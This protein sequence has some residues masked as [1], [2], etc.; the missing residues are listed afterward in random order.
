MKLVGHRGAKG[1]APENTIRSIQ[2]A[3]EY[4]VDEVEIDVR[5]TSDNVP[6]LYHNRSVSTNDGQRFKISNCKYEDLKKYKHDITTLDEAISTVH[7]KSKLCIEVKPRVNIAPIVKLIHSR[8]ETDCNNSDLQLAS[9]SFKILK[10]FK[11]K[12][13]QVELVVIESW[14]GVRAGY[15]ARYL[16]AEHIS[17]NQ[18][19]LWSGYLKLASKHDGKIYA[20]TLNNPK[21]AKRLE[22]SGLAGVITDY[23]DRY[24]N[25][26]P[27]S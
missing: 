22:S 5:V 19:W 24:S 23:P 25:Q 16:N 8:L 14:S 18:R 1:L 26:K 10:D 9:F 2:K 6:I 20:Y 15:R 21:K 7:G 13:P 3:L 12:L 4:G 11:E 27:R 17:L